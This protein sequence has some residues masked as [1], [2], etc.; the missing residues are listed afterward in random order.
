MYK[1]ISH[2]VNNRLQSVVNRFTSRVQKGFT[3][4]RYIQEV[5][6]NVCKKISFCNNNNVCGALLSIDQSRAFDTIS[7]R[8]MTE[9]YRFFGFCMN[10]INMMDTLGTGRT[11]SIIYED[12]EISEEFDLETGRPQGDGPSPLQYNM[13]EEIILLKIELDPRVASVFQHEIFPRFAMNL[14]PDPRRKGLDVDY[15]T[16]LSQESNRETD[17]AD[18]FADDNSTAT[19]ATADSLR[20]LAEICTTFSEFSGLKSN[21]E[22]TTLLRIGTVRELDEETRRIGFNLTE[23]VTLLGMVI[24]RDLSALTETFEEV[25]TKIVR[26][27]EYWDRFKLTLAGRI[28]VCKTFMLSQIGYLGSIITPT[29]AQ[30]KKIQ[31]ALDNFC[32]GK[33]RIAKKND[34]TLSVRGVSG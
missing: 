3:K 24:N 7:H 12:G 21:A 14:V 23:E 18:G 20:Y 28:S 8:Y 22:K 29:P 5:L 32:L 4:H 16:H 2:A 26:M 10:F 1:V 31:D 33:M 15:N 9:V 34:T 27:V 19:L 6:I 25:Y 30:F 13:G 11:A 17:K